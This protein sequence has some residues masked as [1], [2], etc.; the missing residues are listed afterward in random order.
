MDEI[1]N[2][3]R[4]QTLNSKY[5][6]VCIGDTIYQMR[7]NGC[8]VLIPVTEIEHLPE[9][10]A[11]VAESDLKAILTRIPGAVIIP[12]AGTTD[13]C[14]MSFHDNKGTQDHPEAGEKKFEWTYKYVKAA[15]GH[16]WKTTVTMINYKKKNGKWKK[17]NAICAL[18]LSTKLYSYMKEDKSCSSDGDDFEILNT[19]NKY[20][21]RTRIKYT[22]PLQTVDVVTYQIGPLTFTSKEEIEE[23]RTDP[24]GSYI[25]C[26]HQGWTYQFN[27]ATALPE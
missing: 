15:A 22:R 9:V 27:A 6:E 14:Y 7:S 12:K 10:R 13:A 24:Y 4:E 25:Q 20:Y 18:A 26:R 8:Q 16:K 3:P 5:H 21:S 11:A 23:L 19:P 17:D 2:C 1:V